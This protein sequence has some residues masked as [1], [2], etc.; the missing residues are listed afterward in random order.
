M[1][2]DCLTLSSQSQKFSSLGGTGSFS[3]VVS[4]GSCPWTVRNES[5]WIT[6]TSIAMGDG[7]ATITF[8]VLPTIS[9]RSGRLIIGSKV[10]TILQ[11][12]LPCSTALNFSSPKEQIIPG[13]DLLGNTVADF[14]GDGIADF[15]G[16]YERGRQRIAI[17]F[18]NGVGGFGDLKT[19]SSNYALSLTPADLN[20]DG[21]V[22]LAFYELGSNRITIMLNDGRGNFSVSQRIEPVGSLPDKYEI[23][24]DFMFGDFNNDGKLDL[25]TNISGAGAIR[26]AIIIAGNGDGTFGDGS[27]TNIISMIPIE[28][29]RIFEIGDFDGDGNLDLADWQSFELIRH[30]KEIYIWSGDGKGGFKQTAEILMEIN[31]WDLNANDFNGDGRTDL[32]AYTTLNSFKVVLARPSG[33]FETPTDYSLEENIGPAIFTGDVTGDA[34]PEVIINYSLGVL[35]NLGNGHFATQTSYRTVGVAFLGDTNGDGTN[36]L[37]LFDGYLSN[38]KVTTIANRTRCLAPNMVTATS[39]ASYLSVKPASES[40]AT[41]FGQS[42]SNQTL[43]AAGLPLPTSL[44]NTSVKIKDSKGNEHLAPIFFTSPGQINFQLPQ[45]A[46]LGTAVVSVNKSDGSIAAGVIEI[47]NVNPGIFSADASG[48]GLAA[49]VVLRVKANGD[50]VYEPLGRFDPATNRFVALPIDVSNPAEQVFLLIYGTGFRH[51]SGLNNI[52]VTINGADAEVLFAGAQGGFVGL[53]QCNVRL[54]P[55]L[56]GS[57]EISIALTVDGK[58]SNTVKARIK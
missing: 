1:A 26:R 37:I 29:S 27:F 10:F 28:V 22:D 48:A 49:A 7:N 33:G 44:G 45:A 41:L 13:F 35:L 42:L 46:S 56:A 8:T 15:V 18:G 55:S 3:I 12:V 5:S 39:A 25:V 23:E 20:N 9:A 11:E 38:S 24:R 31:F 40:I 57:G 58:T 32:V 4:S 50:Q 54:M 19:Y 34:K 36:D 47:T 51:H 14:N 52:K 30:N 6:L 53:D 2:A 17:M 16:P 43:S 21:K